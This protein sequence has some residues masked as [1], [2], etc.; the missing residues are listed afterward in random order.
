MDNQQK[1][2]NIIEINRIKIIG[3]RPFIMIILKT[4]VYG[5]LLNCV[6]ANTSKP[7]LFILIAKN[8]KHLKANKFC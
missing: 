2:K 3:E 6:L 8:K 4:A 7:T 1:N 5:P